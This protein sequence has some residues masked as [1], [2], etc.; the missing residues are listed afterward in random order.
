MSGGTHADRIIELLARTPGL[1]DDEIAKALSINPRQAVNQTCRLLESKGILTRQRGP[2]GKIVNE[3]CK[4]V[5]APVTRAVPDTRPD[6]VASRPVRP[7]PIMTGRSLGPADP[8]KTLVIVPCSKAKIR[9]AISET[10]GDSIFRHL[11]NDLAGELREARRRVHERIPIDETTLIPAWELYDG[12]LYR[13]GRQALV[14]L[15]EAGYHII[16][17]SGGYGAVLATEPVGWY[18]AKLSPSWWPSNILE[19]VII[20][21]AKRQELTSVRALVSAT[22]SYR[23]VLNRVPWRD[24]GFDDAM[25]LTPHAGKGGTFKSPATIG[26]AL[27]LLADGTLTADWESSYGLGLDVA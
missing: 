17:L 5:S 15:A 22:S 19:R 12:S 6:K 16:I 10:G 25:L 9:P 13:A 24:E 8:A 4:G 26:Q 20:A 21:Y 7:S 1:D 3:L 18:E 11:P 14:S 23:T 2:R 27:C